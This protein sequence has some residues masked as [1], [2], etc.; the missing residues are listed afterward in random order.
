MRLVSFHCF[1]CLSIKESGIVPESH[2]L[3]RLFFGGI[4]GVP[5]ST[6]APKKRLIPGETLCLCK[7]A[8]VL[9]SGRKVAPMGF[10]SVS[11][12]FTV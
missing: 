5:R 7:K 3:P 10:G 12:S 1:K 11:A 8:T 4:G 9:A 6:S 2:A